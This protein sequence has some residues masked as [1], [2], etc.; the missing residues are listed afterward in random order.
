MSFVCNR[1]CYSYFE[2]L[3]NNQTLGRDRRTPNGRGI[4]EN[5]EQESGV[6]NTGTLTINNPAD[7]RVCGIHS[8]RR[9][10]RQRRE[11]GSAGAG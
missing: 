8:Q 1:S 5:A 4:I 9:P 10:C 11:Q 6:N 7:L 3:G 2:L